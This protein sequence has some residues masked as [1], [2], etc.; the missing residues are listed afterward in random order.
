MHF[1][2]LV[3]IPPTG[4]PVT[5]VMRRMAPYDENTTNRKY[6]A[7]EDREEENRDEWQHGVA[8]MVKAPDGE[9][10][11]PWD[12]RFRIGS[13]FSVTKHTYDVPP[14]YEHVRR[15][16]REIYPRFEHYLE[17][18][19]GLSVDEEKNR[20]GVW[21]NP[22]GRWDFYQIGGRWTGALDGYNPDD[23]PANQEQC[24]ACNGSGYRDEEPCSACEGAGRSVVW[25]TRWKPHSGDVQNASVALHKG[26][27]PY[28]LV[29]NDAQWFCS[30]VWSNRD[31]RFLPTIDDWEGFVREC[32]AT[33]KGRVAV[34]DYHS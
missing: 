22:R 4:D 23:D 32:L 26:F 17:D 13:P 9:F 2:A 34:V 5:Q 6:L 30:E 18:F 27:I 15:R 8:E 25:P 21:R 20:Y 7:F 10:L 33:H 11:W 29:S 3:F 28:S 24:R 14:D 12:D 31:R 16:F 19:C 1:C